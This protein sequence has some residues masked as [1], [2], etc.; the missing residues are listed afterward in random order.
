[1]GQEQARV[2]VVDIHAGVVTARHGPLAARFGRYGI[3]G[4]DELAKQIPQPHEPWAAAFFDELERIFA[5]PANAE[6]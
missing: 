2:H 5:E 3:A 6:E 1:M 4:L